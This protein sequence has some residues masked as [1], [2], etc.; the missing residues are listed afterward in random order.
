MS[1]IHVHSTVSRNGVLAKYNY[2]NP[3]Q[4]MQQ[5]G[6]VTPPLYNL[7]NI[8]RNISLFISY[9]G[10][11]YISDSIDVTH[12]LEKLKNH[13]SDKITVH[14]VKDFGHA[15]FVMGTSV[16]ENVYNALVRFLKHQ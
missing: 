1:N 13:E 12:L 3:M 5:Y 10:K 16:K 14:F 7:E 2:G 11:D 15:D 4:N 8:P 6:M 9:G